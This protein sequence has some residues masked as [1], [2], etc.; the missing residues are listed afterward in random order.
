MAF[1]GRIFIARHGET[2]FNAARRMQ[3]TAQQTP[4]THNG[5][6]QADAMGKALAKWLGTH[7]TLELWASP[8]GRALQTMAIA[9][10]HLSGDY[11][12]V[13]QDARLREID[14]GRWGGMSYA[15]VQREY[16]PFI[17]TNTGLFTLVPEDGE[18]YAQVGER[19]REWIDHLPPHP[20]DR[21]VVMHG[22]SSRVLRGLLLG[23]EPHPR[24]GV[25]IAP[26]VAQGSLVMIGGG[27]EKLI[28]VDHSGDHE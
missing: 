26:A 23:L 7:Q 24:F 6:A 8:A 17:E 13:Q 15:D 2:V 21:L 18:S 27:V 16:G 14:T 12:T 20:V 4:L 5:F 25:P 1:P 22:M 9:T 19:L 11:F 3:G 28:R 10:H